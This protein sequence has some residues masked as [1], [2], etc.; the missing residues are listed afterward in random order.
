MG[1]IE[2]RLVNADAI[3]RG[4]YNGILL[5]MK[6]SAELLSLPGGIDNFGEGNLPRGSA[7]V[8]GGAIVTRCQESMF[9][10]EQRADLT[11][12]ACRSLGDL[13]SDAHEVFV[14][15]RTLW[16]RDLIVH[17]ESGRGKSLH[18]R[19]T[20]AFTSFR[21]DSLSGEDK[22]VSNHLGDLRHLD[23]FHSPRCHGR[24][25]KTNAAGDG[26]FLCVI[27]DHVLVDRNAR[28]VEPHFGLLA[29]E[30]PATQV[31]E[32]SDDVGS[33]R[34]QSNPCRARA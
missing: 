18:R 16:M 6:S 4:L 19:S 25:A 22:T 24:G 13:A 1:A 3:E 34:D 11:T 31:Y 20:R 2:G 5:G 8:P 10:D 23:F 12:E 29:G 33:S 27:G 9:T 7:S 14:P 15:G 28:A 21:Q 17:G 26:R 32:Q 30:L